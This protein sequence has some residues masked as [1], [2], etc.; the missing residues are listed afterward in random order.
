MELYW[1]VRDHLTISDYRRNLEGVREVV[2]RILEDFRRHEF[3]AT[4]ATVGFLLF[5]DVADLLRHAPYHRP[6]YD[7]PNLSPYDYLSKIGH[8]EHDPALHFAPDLIR[9]IAGTPHQEIA[10]H[11][12]SHYYC[13]EPGS[14]GETFRCDLEAAL[15]ASAGKTGNTP[16]SIVFPRNQMDDAALQVCRD[17]GLQA[18][19]GNERAWFYQ[20]RVPTSL[21]L[22][23]RS[24]RLL[25]A[26]LP[27]TGSNAFP[28]RHVGALPVNVPASRFLR[29]YSRRL[30]FLE[31]LRVKRIESAMTTAAQRGLAFHLWWHP[32][33]F[34]I[35]QD[36]NLAILERLLHHHETLR[37]RYGMRS[38]TMAEAARECLGADPAAIGRNHD[39]SLSAG[40]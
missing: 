32:H 17:Q 16:V 8:G 26:Y 11:T 29:P 12:F 23:Q 3:H 1:G 34:G 4:W 24:L 18:Y 6:S 37:A 30:A 7:D 19:R 13:H 36:E 9:Q 40:A 10:T 14:S 33:N 28:L 2:P 15:R 31:P 25:D 35:N 21:R 22:L 5:D 38:M 27:L 20:S 39:V